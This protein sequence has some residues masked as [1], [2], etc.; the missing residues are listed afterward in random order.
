MAKKKVLIV[1]DSPTVVAMTRSMLE[2]SGYEAISA[3]SG[4]E[5]LESI[6]AQK[7]DLIL[8]DVML[9]G[10]DGYQVCRL[11]KFDESSKNIPVIMLTSRAADSDKEKA[12]QV[13]ADSY[14]IKS[15]GDDVLANKIKELIK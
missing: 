4:P 8:L 11:V 1:D 7:P 13:G 10:M 2:E 14:L 15:F 6:K 5:A 9:P 12:S 3:S